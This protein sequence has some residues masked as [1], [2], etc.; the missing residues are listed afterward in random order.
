LIEEEGGK[1]MD[2]QSSRIIGIIG[3]L[4]MVLGIIPSVGGIIMLLGLILVLVALKGYA[5]TYKESSIFNNALYS[6]IFILIGAVVTIVILLYAAVGFAASLGINNLMD[7][8]SWQQIDWQEAVNFDTIQSFLVP[9]ILA[10]IVLV[11]FVIFAGFYFKKAM[12][13]LSEK[14]KVNLFHTTGTVF[15]VGAILTIIAI[16]LFIIYVSFILL[17]IS[18]YESKPLEQTPPP[19]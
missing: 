10:L 16:G 15:F 6:I 8:A 14:T 9:V 17:L 1:K 12:N 2:I 3:A 13:T 4:L 7:L 19:Q 18:F 5:D 11:A